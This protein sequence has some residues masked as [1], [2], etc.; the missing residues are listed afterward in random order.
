MKKVSVIVPA[1]N[2]EKYLEECLDSICEQTYPALEILVVDDGSK[3]S[4]AS[5]IRNRAEQDVRIIPYYNE[6]HGVSYSRNFG[7]EHCTGEYVTFI[8]ADD[9]A[10]P[11]FV[12]QMVHDLEGAVADMAVIGVAKSKLFKPEMF[13]NGLVS[14][15]EKSEMLKQVFGTFEGFVCNKLYKKSLLQTKAIRLEQNIVVCEDLL[16]NVLYLL[17]CKKAVYNSGKKYFYRQ[18]ENSASNRLDNPKWFDA[19]KAYQQIIQL[20]KDYPDVYQRATFQYAM[21]LCAA[22]Y[23]ILFIED[24]NGEL[25]Q[26]V[27]EEWKRLRPE[28]KKFSAKQRMKLYVFSVAPKTVI[29]YQRR[30][31]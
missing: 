25:R 8:D 6:N 12:A 3:D 1:Y 11:D 22:K 17:N 15:Y 31:L 5:I 23:R 9:L 13:T 30:M 28:W 14:T 29:K 16:F 2:A 19:M 18:I 4:T 10:A 20:V 7:L 27:Y 26:K 21:F 24:S